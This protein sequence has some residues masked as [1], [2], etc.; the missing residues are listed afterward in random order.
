MTS[1]T[2]LS[3]I[4]V[5]IVA[6]LH[7]TAGLLHRGVLERPTW[8]SVASG[9]AVAYV[10][11]HLLPE[12][13]ETQARFLEARPVRSLV[14]LQSHVY[15]AALVGVLLALGLDRATAHPGEQRA[16]FWLHTGSF[17]LYNLLVGGLAL[18][19]TNVPTLILA[20]IAFGAHFLV[21]DHGLQVEYGRAYTRF[22]R[23]LLAAAIVVGWAIA[24]ATRPPPAVV[25]VLLGLLSGSIILNVLKDEL[26][27]RREGRF[28]AFVLG[29]IGYALLLLALSYTMQAG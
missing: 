17:A 5:S 11:V 16:R 18:R 23:W 3:L 24:L 8:L 19:V 10:F 4:G 28:L 15:L 14:W 20:V 2:M 9:L 13:A 12:L 25:V 29:A 21:N 1:S 27:G 6:T 7:V 26:P 22:G